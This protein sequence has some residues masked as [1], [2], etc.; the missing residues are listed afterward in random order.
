[1]P[2]GKMDTVQVE[3]AVM[4]EKRALSPGFILFRQGVVETT[5]CAGTRGNSHQGLSDFPYF[6]RAYSFH[7][8][9][10]ERFSHL[11]FISVVTLEDLTVECP[12]SISGDLKILK[13]SC[14]GY[15]ITGVRTIAIAA[16]SG[17]AFS[18]GCPNA[19]FQLFTHDLFE[20]HLDGTHRQVPEI[21]TKILLFWEDS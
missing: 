20:Q 13:A 5:H 16:T 1:M 6:M 19:L 15:Q 21:L 12:F 10:S 11:R 2:D 8:H 14:G 9:L 4:G 18:P 17:S 3:D 7:K